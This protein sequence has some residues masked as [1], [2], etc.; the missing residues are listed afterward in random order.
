MGIRSVSRPGLK[1]LTGILDTEYLR[2]DGGNYL[3]EIVEDTTPEL[4]GDLDAGGNN[5]D[6]LGDVTFRTGAQGGTVRTG[7]S[8]ADF[9]RLQAYDVNGGVYETVARADAGIDPQFGLFDGSL[10]IRNSADDTK[11]IA[12]NASAI[13]TGTVRTITMP[14]SDVTL[15]TTE[16]VQDIIGA[17]VTGNTENRITVTYEDGDGTIDF[18]VDPDL[19]NYTNSQGWTSNTGTV[20]SVA[21]SGSDGIEVDSGSPITTSG[22]IALGVDA[23]ALRT[24]INVEDG[25]TADQTA[26][27][28]EAI[29]NHDNLLGFEANEHIDW[30]NATD[31]F[32]T[33]GT[34]KAKRLTAEDTAADPYVELLS[35][36]AGFKIVAENAGVDDYLSFIKNGSPDETLFRILSNGNFDFINYTIPKTG[37]SAGGYSVLAGAGVGGELLS[38]QQIG[39]EVSQ[40]EAEAGTSTDIKRWTPQRIAQAIA[41]LETTA[42]VDS[43]NGQTGVVVLD[44][45]DLDDTSTTNKFT[46]AS[47]ISKLAGIE[48]GA[49]VTDET[50]VVSALDGAT[51]TDIGTP[52]SGDLVL[53]QDVSDS[54]NLK[55]AQFSTFGG[56]GGVSDGDKGDITVSSSG[57]VWTIDAG[58]VTEAKTSF[59]TE[60]TDGFTITSGSTSERDLSV[61]GSDVSVVGSG[62]ATYTYPAGTST[63]AS[64]GLSETFTN[65]TLGSGTKVGIGSDATGDIY[66]RDASGNLTRLAIGSNGNFLTISAGLPAW[67]SSSTVD[68]TIYFSSG[69]DSVTATRYLGSSNADTTEDHVRRIAPAG[70]VTAMYAVREVDSGTGTFRLRKNG[71]YVSGATVAI[72]SGTT[73]N[74]TGLSVSFNGTTDTISMEVEETTGPTSGNYFIILYYTPTSPS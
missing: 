52:A 55:V 60:N 48:A 35:S 20:T 2:I 26:G 32:L 6:N 25:A 8:N 66:Y 28:I 64:T 9:Y 74:V 63:L 13:T 62:A 17:M 44:P 36:T 42:P 40:A 23:A 56:G 27:E 7:T 16:A 11:R 68:R 33:T 5:I 71:S 47:D 14:D 24:H 65:K 72:S 10:T 45:D 39:E 70:T 19:G 31:N 34:A 54:N 4:G 69:S 49:D 46:T 61:S 22:T 12:L 37:P 30:T 59:V 43:V 50:N 29:V 21:V 57:T 51:L 3:Q 67:A 73:G 1:Y 18:V 58:V 53:V 38:W 15:L 41:A